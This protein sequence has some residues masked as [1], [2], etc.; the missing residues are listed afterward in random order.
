MVNVDKKLSFFVGE[1]WDT[2][3]E[4]IFN[5]LPGSGFVLIVQ[6]LYL[7]QTTTN[8]G[9]LHYVQDDDF[10]VNGSG[11]DVETTMTKQATTKQATTNAG[12][13][14]CVQDDSIPLC[15]IPLCASIFLCGSI[16]L[17]ASIFLCS[18]IS[19]CFRRRAWLGG[20]RWIRLEP[21]GL[22]CPSPGC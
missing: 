22:A 5:I 4:Y 11:D 3:F 18:N 6:R 14:H 8:T 7:E 12:I 15:Y 13:L 9:I 16:R 1:K 21:G 20:G 17:C 10:R 2:I 19:L